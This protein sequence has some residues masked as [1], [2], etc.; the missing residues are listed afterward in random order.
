MQELN[1]PPLGQLK[2][3]DSRF[4]FKEA[5]KLYSCLSSTG[6]DVFDQMIPKKNIPIR[7]YV[8][9]QRTGELPVMVYF[10]GGGWVLGDL[11]SS[12]TFCQY[13]SE[14]AQCII[15]SV[16]YRLA[17]EHKY[18]AALEDAMDAVLWIYEHIHEFNGD[19]E[20]L[21]IGGDSS[22]ANIATVTAY[23]IHKETPISINHQLLL[24]PVT[25]YKYQSPSYLA[26]YSFGLSKET[27]D[28]FWQHYL[29]DE[30]EGLDPFVSPLLIEELE[31]MPSTTIVT[32]EFDILRD[33]G[34]A[35]AK[36]LEDNGVPV[37]YLYYEGLVHNF[38][39]MIGNVK[40]AKEAVDDLIGK[41]IP[42]F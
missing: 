9:K 27:M 30:E 19:K 22:G 32:A 5:R 34:K 29:N 31:K 14:K 24:V 12:N 23:R 10:H 15:V 16:D 26:D 13:L 33:E 6:I 41:L 35:F 39:F 18:P 25:Y 38:P 3:S 28:W 37:Q 7:V 2:A 40:L 17:P 42:Y 4:F 1:H 8:P 36:K 21:S 20:R 11:N